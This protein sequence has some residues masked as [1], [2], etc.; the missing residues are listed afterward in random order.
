M[1][2]SLPEQIKEVKLEIILRRSAYPK[3]V[4]RGKMK[5]EVAERRLDIMQA[6]LKTLEDLERS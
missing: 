3:F 6:V 5:P 4:D 1:R 2:F